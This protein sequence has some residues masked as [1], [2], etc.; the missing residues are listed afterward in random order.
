MEIILASFNRDKAKEIEKIVAPIKVK[1]LADM[2]VSIDFDEIETG[3]TFEENALIK[4]RAAAEIADGISVADD[5]GLEVEA[6]GG[7][8]GILSARY[9]GA[10]A[11]Y[12]QK[13]ELMLDEM[14]NV[15]REKRSARFVCVV[16]ARF[17]EG[18]EKIFEGEC[19]GA[20]HTEPLGASGFGFDP[21]FFLP[22]LGKTMAQISLDE[23]N[24]ISH[25]AAAF[26]KLKEFLLNE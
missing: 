24:L 3:S 14:K 12:A 15:P 4:A 11:G 16:A 6:L 25:R 19:R 5:S 10:A 23:K 17:P 8:P 13:C 20:I 22:Q 1:C 2:G 21:V 26:R 7:R 9:G 18:N